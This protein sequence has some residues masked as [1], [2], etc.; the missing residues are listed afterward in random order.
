MGFKC[1]L[2][3]QRERRENRTRKGKREEGK[4]RKEEE[5]F[6]FYKRLFIMHC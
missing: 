1:H 4:E 6:P 5:R 2:D 3:F